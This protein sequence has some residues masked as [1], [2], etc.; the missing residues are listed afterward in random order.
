MKTYTI[1]KRTAFS[2]DYIKYIFLINDTKTFTYDKLV[3][4][5]KS[6]AENIKTKHT[7]L[8]VDTDLTAIQGFG[9]QPTSGEAS[10]NK[11]RSLFLSIATVSTL[12][13]NDLI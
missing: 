12:C 6:A 13:I 3:S 10:I 11:I 4:Y 1:R 5:L 7:L 2:T 9:V 8:I